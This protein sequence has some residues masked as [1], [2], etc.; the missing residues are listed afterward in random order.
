MNYAMRLA[1]VAIVLIA[2]IVTSAHAEQFVDPSATFSIDI[3]KG[4]TS[5]DTE[6]VLSLAGPDKISQMNI[7]KQ[8]SEGITRDQFAQVFPA[9][10]KKEL[11]KFKLISSAKTKVGS[12]PAGVWVY[13]AKIDGIVLKFK[14]YVIFPADAQVMYNVV[15]ATTPDRF[16]KN[17]SAFDAMVKSWSWSKG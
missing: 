1:T 4:W 17:A 16:T 13:T 15:F 7:S 8:D 14:N 3:A 11:A 2:A 5:Q 9:Q 6:D 10:M 12:A